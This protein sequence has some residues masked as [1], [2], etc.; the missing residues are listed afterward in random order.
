MIVIGA[1]IL[2]VLAGFIVSVIITLL[3]V[4]VAVVGIFLVLGGIAMML[5]GGRFWRGR[6]WG[7]DEHPAS[8]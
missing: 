2:I 7:W 8:T 4:L 6:R 1:V 3:K 5:F